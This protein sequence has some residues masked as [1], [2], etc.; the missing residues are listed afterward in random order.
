MTARKPLVFAAACIGMLFFGVALLSMG[1]LLPAIAGRFQLDSLSSGALV[2]ILPFG[3]LAGSVVFGPIVDRFGYKLLLVVS[4]LV[5]IAGLEALAFAPS[6]GVLR[7][8]ILAIGFGGGVL[9][10]GTNALVADISAGER[11]AKLSLLGVFF[12]LGALGMPVLLGALEGVAYSVVLSRIGFV[13]VLPVLYFAVITFPA[14]KQAQGFPLAQGIG[15]LRDGGLMLI[16]VTLALQ[17]GLE[18]VV[19]NWT[20]TYLASGRGLGASQALFA[21]SAFVAGMVVAR[22][23]LTWVLRHLAGDRVLYLSMELSA[24]GIALVV[25]AGTS[26]GL[27]AFGFAVLGVGLAAGFPLLLGYVADLYPSIS[28]TAFS[29][30]LAIALLGNMGIN[31][32]VGVLSDTVGPGYLPLY[33]GVCLALQLAVGLA[34]LRSFKARVAAAR[35]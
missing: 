29:V 22:L 8:A 18:G 6:V 5:M 15:L 27:A 17:S 28:G 21:L 3:V 26:A 30:V 33:L 25:A 20:T 23:A 35:P 14:P 24:I 9:N 11:G 19:N 32:L 31:Y 4:A 10:G 16:A 13:L 1:S 7:L 2:S 12:G 34:A